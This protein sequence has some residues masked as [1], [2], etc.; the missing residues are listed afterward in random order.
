MIIKGLISEDFINYKKTSMTIMFPYC[1]DF[2]CGAEYCQNSP[3]AKSKNIELSV[4]NII[5]KYIKNPITESVVMQGLEPLD[6]WGDLQNFITE[7]RQKTQDDIVIYT[8]YNKEEILQHIDWLKQFPNIIVKFGRF[9]PNQE[10]HYDEVLGIHL[11]SP[12]QYAE[13]IS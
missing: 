11:A 6:S 8:G 13:K 5:E 12:N 4:K 2:K 9:I 10:K 3:L 7:L 1:I